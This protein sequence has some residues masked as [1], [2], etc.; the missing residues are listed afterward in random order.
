MLKAVRPDERLPAG[1]SRPTG[2][3]DARCDLRAN[4][5]TDTDDEAS[6]I[7]AAQGGD[8]AA[9]GTLIER[10]WDHLFRWLC[11]LSRDPSIAEDLTQETF[12]KAFAAVSRF[13]AGSNFRAW[14]FRIGHNN[15]VNQRRTIRHQRQPLVPEIAEEPQGPVGNALTKEALQVVADAI[16]KLPSDFRAALLLR[17]EDDL[18][19]REIAEIL[20]ITEET[21]RWRVFKARQKLM[22]VLSADFLPHGSEKPKAS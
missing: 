3:E 11:R 22:T 6:L 19:F 21:A 17:I 15:F 9:F 2:I 18:S 4:G 1:L 20:E 7:R 8:R 16:K 14:L 12:L 10:Y 5:S 13:E